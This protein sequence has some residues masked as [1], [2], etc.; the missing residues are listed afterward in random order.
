MS[1]YQVVAVKY[2]RGM[3]FV[4][5]VTVQLKKPD[6]SEVIEAD[7][8]GNGPVD[9]AFKAIQRALGITIELEDFKVSALGSGSDAEGQVDVQ[10]KDNGSTHKGQG[11]STDIIIASVN[12]FVDALN[13]KAQFDAVVVAHTV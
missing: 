8:S 10:I 11:R 2:A 7:V 1:E 9:A 4:P 3:N 6:A 13:K 5:T 12:A